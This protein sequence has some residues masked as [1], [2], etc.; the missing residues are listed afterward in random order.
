MVSLSNYMLTWWPLFSPGNTL[1]SPIIPLVSNILIFCD[2]NL[3]S[4]ALGM[5]KE[6]MLEIIDSGSFAL[7]K[8]E[9]TSFSFA[10]FSN[11]ISP[12]VEI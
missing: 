12:F 5:D 6:S 3:V 7:A 1:Y 9:A 11:C 4:S 8:M 2:N 10:L